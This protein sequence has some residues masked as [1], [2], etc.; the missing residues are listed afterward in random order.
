MTQHSSHPAA[1]L[2]QTNWFLL[3]CLVYEAP[4][5]TCINDVTTISY[6]YTAHN[7]TCVEAVT[8]CISQKHCYKMFE[9]HFS[10]K[11]MRLHKIN[12]SKPNPDWFDLLAI[13]K[14]KTIR[15]CI[16]VNEKVKKMHWHNWAIKHFWWT[17]IGTPFTFTTF[18][19]QHGVRVMAQ[20]SD[21]NTTN[22]GKK[23]KQ[24]IHIHLLCFFIILALCHFDKA[25]ALI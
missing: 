2:L 8:L 16:I 23:I 25:V 14:Q 13:Q 21:T 11:E 20:I 5:V 6:K 4:E 3:S 7:R 17:F 10:M 24:K 22:S 12:I 1:F 15:N 9:I 19:D 18:W